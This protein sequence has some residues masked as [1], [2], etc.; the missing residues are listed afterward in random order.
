MNYYNPD[1]HS[2]RIWGGVAAL[3]YFLLLLC[4]L[5][6]VR[7][8]FANPEREDMGILINFGESEVGSGAEDLAATDVA[9]TPPPPTP[10]VVEQPEELLTDENS[11]VAMQSSPPKPTPK[12][13]PEVKKPV[14]EQRIIPKN[15]LYPGRTEKSTA[16]SQ[17]VSEDAVG[18]QGDPSG[19]PE[20]AGG[21]AGGGLIETSFSLNGRSL[22]G[23][24]PKPSYNSNTTGKVVIKVT[25]NELG[26]VT[27]AAYQ[28][29]G[30]TTNSSALVEAARLA[31]L[32]AK[33]SESDNFLQGGTITYIFKMD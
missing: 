28:P 33:F 6:F 19:S 15:T 5:I 23:S 2:S 25:V 16:T 31:A 7:F 18:N 21:G 20:G 12:P 13:M 29:Q 32:K 9:S 3:L 14:E 4:A 27:G 8:D 30:S 24:L 10:K 1:E 17:G 22:V 11:D 26:A